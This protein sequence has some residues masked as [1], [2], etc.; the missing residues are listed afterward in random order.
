MTLGEAY[1]IVGEDVWKLVG[2][3]PAKD[4]SLLEERLKR[5]T[6]GPSSGPAASASRASSIARPGSTFSP[7]GGIKTNAAASSSPTT[8]SKLPS[9]LA[10]PSVAASGI[11]PPK[12]R[13]AAP[14]GLRPPSSRPSEPAQ[15][16][17]RDSEFE[18]DAHEDP[19]GRANGNGSHLDE[20]YKDEEA[21]ADQSQSYRDESD[22][23]AIEQSINEI[24]SSDL[25]RSIA[26]IKTLE[27]DVQ[28]AAP[29]LARH[30]DRLASAS[31]KQLRRAF[32]EGDQARSPEADR[33][34]KHILILINMMFDGRP[35]FDDERTLAS[36]I[37]RSA[38]VP[39]MTEL[40]QRLIH[41]TGKTDNRDSQAYAKNI[42]TLLLRAFSSCNLNALFA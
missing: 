28:E 1:K 2:T 39:L 35:V 13:L 4:K 40:L 30:A 9:R 22:D 42:N 3:L 12:S 23:V 32:A 29:S 8:G 33:L 7:P 11:Q 15:A 26:A 31:T 18:V 21:L 20:E 36:F 16:L 41:V 34:R 14:S 5:T 27:E 6:G 10:R 37:S 38:L 25:Q 19:N 17:K 24:L